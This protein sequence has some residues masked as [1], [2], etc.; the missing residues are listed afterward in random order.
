MASIKDN[1]GKTEKS[2]RP[3]IG[4]ALGGGFARGIAHIGVLKAFADHDISVDCISGT[5]AGALVAATYAFG[6]PLDMLVEKSK[7]LS[8]YSISGFPS[9]K[10][11]I[12]PNDALEKIIEE[13][14]GSADIAKAR[15]PLA[16]IATDIETGEKVVF[17]KGKAGLAARASACIPGLFIPVEIDGKKLVDGGLMENLPLEPLR[18]MGADIAIGVD[19]SQWHG[20][21]KVSNILD[22]MSNAID[23]LASHQKAVPGR[24]IDIVIEPDL[25]AYSSSDFKKADEIV[26]IGYR[27]AVRKIPE[28]R[29]LLEKRGKQEK[30]KNIFIRFW[31]WLLE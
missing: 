4:V 16:I 7:K 23:I 25:G 11:G 5:S 31:N 24:F 30:P 27:A 15:I 3:R 13:F 19:V 9:L 28:I 22:V 17:R 10:L 29:R 12:V 18:E 6:V 20:E 8:W 14:I 2:D 26:A 1:I 21:K